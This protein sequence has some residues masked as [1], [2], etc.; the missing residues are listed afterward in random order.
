MEGYMDEC[1]G[2]RMD[3][4]MDD[5]WLDTRVDVCVNGWIHG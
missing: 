5:G 1:M 4:W 2:G 3:T